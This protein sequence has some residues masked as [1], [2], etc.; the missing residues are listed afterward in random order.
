MAVAL[1]IHSRASA[2]QIW[3][4]HGS[5]PSKLGSFCRDEALEEMRLRVAITI[6]MRTEPKITISLFAFKASDHLAGFL[7]LVLQA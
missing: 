4:A 1:L 5:I 2:T 6:N 7:G 3:S